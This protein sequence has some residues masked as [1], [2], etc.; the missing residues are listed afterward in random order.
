LDVVDGYRDGGGLRRSKG[1][2]VSGLKG[3]G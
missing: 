3:L 1:I 2:H